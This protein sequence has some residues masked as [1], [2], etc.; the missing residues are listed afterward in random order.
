MAGIIKDA[1]AIVL[2]YYCVYISMCGPGAYYRKLVN[3]RECETC[4]GFVSPQCG[5]ATRLPYVVVYGLLQ[6]LFQFLYLIHYSSDY[7]C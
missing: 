7:I 3:M 2:A 1:L 5:Y 6:V 4:T